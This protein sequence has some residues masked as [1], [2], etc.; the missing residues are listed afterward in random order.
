VAKITFLEKQ[1]LIQKYDIGYLYIVKTKEHIKIGISKMPEQRI[2][3]IKT[4]NPYQVDVVM[5]MKVPF[6]YETEQNI[7]KQLKELGW[8]VRG[9]WFY[10]NENVVNEI[11]DLLFG[12][13][14]K[15]KKHIRRLGLTSEFS[16]EFKMLKEYKQGSHT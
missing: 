8:H 6:V 5:V 14:E 10:H 3:L 4:D 12:H 7:H 15:N 1:A 2:N 16:Q 9:E 11:I 13:I